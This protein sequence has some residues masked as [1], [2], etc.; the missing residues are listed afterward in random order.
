MH[1][2]RS[3]IEMSKGFGLKV[4]AEGI[5]DGETFETLRMLGCDTA[6]GWYVAKPM[7]QLQFIE[8]THQY[9]EAIDL[10]AAY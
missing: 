3:I 6:Q 4:V 7:P 1:I 8:W 9:I 2:V 5:E 10:I